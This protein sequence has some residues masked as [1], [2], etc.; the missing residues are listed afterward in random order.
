[1]SETWYFKIFEFTNVC[2][3]Y[4]IKLLFFNLKTQ[5]FNTSLTTY[6]P[7]CDKKF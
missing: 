3:L 7:L 1:M 4:F 5:N 2:S 6:F